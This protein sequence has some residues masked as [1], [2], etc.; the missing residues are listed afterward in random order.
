M[1]DSVRPGG[2]KIE[3]GE[4]RQKNGKKYTMQAVKLM[5]K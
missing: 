1:K 2:Q 4:R 3:T 5:V